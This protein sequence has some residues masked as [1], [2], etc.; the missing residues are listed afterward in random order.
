MAATDFVTPRFPI[1]GADIPVKNT[2]GG[3]LAAGALV[4]I[5]TSNPVSATQP[6]IGVV[7]C[8]AVTDFPLGFLI[9]ALAANAVGRVQI[10]GIAQ[11]IAL[12]AITAGAIVG[13]SAT[14]GQI[15]T[16]TAT[17]PA[18]GQALTAAANAADPILV[19]IAPCR[20]A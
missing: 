15:T 1:Q 9:E 19:R 6:Q 14:A 17:D 2:S 16:Y 13:P 12:G 18:I 5:D 20:N 3:A 8:S 11:G 4:K 10:E 7:A